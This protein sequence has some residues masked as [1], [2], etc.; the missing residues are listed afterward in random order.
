MHRTHRIRLHA[1]WKRA[2]CDSADDVKAAVGDTCDP[3]LSGDAATESVSLPDGSLADCS[4]RFV[5]YSRRFNRPS[6]LEESTAV[7]L[8]SGL[9]GLADD[10]RLNGV[11][12]APSA[13]AERVEIRTHLLPHNELRVKVARDQFAAASRATAYLEIADGPATDES[14]S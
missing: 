14:S 1:A 5:T 3:A 13:D 6:G 9:L 11:P 4:D 8:V 2:A 12:L 7:W 10:V